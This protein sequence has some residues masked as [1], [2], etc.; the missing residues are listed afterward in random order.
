MPAVFSWIASWAVEFFVTY[1]TVGVAYANLVYW[2]AYVL[3]V[4][5]VAYA[6]ISIM[7]SMTRTPSLKGGA[8]GGVNVRDGTAAR[9][10]I[11]G[12]RKTS[13]VLVP[14]AVRPS[15]F[16][17]ETNDCIYMLLILAG[18]PV[19]SIEKVFFGK[20]ELVLDSSGN[21]TG[22]YK[23]YA[24]VVR[25]PQ[26]GYCADITTDLGSHFWTTE[27]RLDGIAYLYIKL[28]LNQT[29]YSGG[30]P[31]IFALVK[32]R[33]VFDPRDEDQDISDLSTWKYSNNPALCALDYLSGVPILDEQ[34]QVQTPY[35]VGAF[36]AETDYAS[37]IAAAN[38]C[39]EEIQ[40]SLTETTPRYTCNGII[41]SATAAGDGLAMIAGAMAGDVCYMGGR[42]TAFAGAYRN[43]VGS[44]S[45]SDFRAPISAINFVRAKRDK[46]N[47]VK[48][49]FVD[50]RNDY[51]VVDFPPVTS[52]VFFAED[53]NETLYRDVEYHLTTDEYAARRLARI[54]LNSGRMSVAF[55]ARCN[56][57][58]AKYSINDTITYSNPNYGWNSKPF[59]VVGFKF[60]EAQDE[61]NN[62]ML[63]IDL[64]L[65][66]TT[67]SIYTLDAADVNPRIYPGV[68]LPD[69]NTVQNVAGFGLLSD[70]TTSIIQPDGTAVPRVRVS[71]TKPTDAYVLGG[72]KT[73]I[74]YR[75]DENA[76]WVY[77]SGP[78]GSTT[79]DFITDVK[80]GEK[81]YVRTCHENA[82]KALG[83]WV[84][85]SIDVQVET[86]VDD[87]QNIV[88]NG[89]FAAGDFGWD[90]RTG[91]V[92]NSS[93]GEFG[94]GA[95][96]TAS[97]GR[98]TN[99]RKIAVAGG[100]VF[101]LRAR[102][103][104]TGAA[105]RCVFASGSNEEII[106]GSEWTAITGSNTGSWN[107]LN[108]RIV[109]PVGVRYMQVEGLGY[110]SGSRLDNI[111]LYRIVT[112]NE[113][114]L[115]SV[116]PESTTYSGSL[117]VSASHIDPT[118]VIRATLNGTSVT[119]TSPVF[120]SSLFTST[121]TLKVRAY[122][123]NA[124]SQ[125]QTFI[126][127]RSD[128]TS[129]PT[130]RT[131]TPSWYYT[132]NMGY[133]SI[134][135]TLSCATAGATIYYRIGVGSWTTYTGPFLLG[136]NQRATFYAVA[137]GYLDS[138]EN[139]LWNRAENNGGGGILP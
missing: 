53:N 49:L 139:E 2:G 56:L 43:P 97:N 131:A 100:D 80:A 47:A 67:S 4:A 45:D 40:V 64:D 31:D 66:E 38:I 15:T 14:L 127:T 105:V 24:K 137:S 104:G 109:A 123:D 46:Y 126:Y 11:Y 68:L 12:E 111:N 76:E 112:E 54:A 10:I 60:A 32:G 89:R 106:S 61:N 27:H 57:S 114:S 13:G 51:Q 30:V 58:A 22:K 19:D 121:T 72:G 59:R 117:V 8:F 101:L 41:S 110:S 34:S 133:S 129:T 70:E 135:V 6:S 69:V 35:G 39:D 85:G 113:L 37:F 116:T 71:W 88:L 136:L 23:D 91:F 90:E 1:G 93:S 25:K 78:M 122:A 132:G 73:N 98:L 16:L 28:K 7:R 29:L 84:S 118:A 3:A 48:G 75:K 42:W 21:E 36:P 125:E 52:S 83:S 20:D 26:G 103:F 9:N 63:G 33:R 107:S 44:I 82:F 120:S 5:V 95:A 102:A 96:C 74:E 17:G 65:Q 50:K 128:A 115:P 62:S 134:T 81:V 108:R 18:T 77:W 99:N 130:L 87:P 119:P 138:Y 79:N 94:W 86:V 92:I 55:T 124:V